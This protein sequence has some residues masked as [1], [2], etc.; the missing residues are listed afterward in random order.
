MIVGIGFFWA[1]VMVKP[2]GPIRNTIWALTLA[3]G[4]R[5]LPTAFG[6]ISPMLARIG[7]ELDDAARTSGADW[8]TTSRTILLV[9]L[10]P[11]LYSSFVLLFIQLIKEYG[12]AV[13]LVAPGSEVMGLTMLQFWVQG[14]AGPVAALSLLQVV[15]TMVIVYAGRKLFKVKV[16]A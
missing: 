7:A 15:I 10:K 5:Y 11:A 16:Y 1:F 8:W 2:L 3:F 6:A 9:L 14:E 13:F 12:S 4:V